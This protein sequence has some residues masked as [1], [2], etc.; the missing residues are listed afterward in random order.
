MNGFIKSAVTILQQ[1]IKNVVDRFFSYVF[2]VRIKA[3]GLFVKED[4]DFRKY[5]TFWLTHNLSNTL[6]LAYV[7]R[8]EDYWGSELLIFF[9]TDNLTNTE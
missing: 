2:Y 3:V 8:E 5:C 9:Y 1:F 6:L 4:I 7:Y